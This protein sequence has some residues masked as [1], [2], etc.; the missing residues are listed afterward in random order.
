MS[1]K[2]CVHTI[3]SQF[4]NLVENRF[5]TKIKSLYSDNGGEYIALKNYL[6]V[7][8]IGHYT[9][10][11]HTPQQ[12]RISERRHQHLVET[13][14]TLLTD[15]HMPLSYWPYAFQAATYL[16]NRMPTSTLNNKTPFELLFHQNPNYMKLKQFG[17]LFYPLTRPYNTHKLQTKAMSCVFVGYSLTQNAYLC[18]NLLSRKV[19]HSRH[20]LFDETVF[21]MAQTNSC[22]SAKSQPATSALS[23]SHPVT[24]S[25]PLLYPARP[26][27]STASALGTAAPSSPSV[28]SPPTSVPSQV[29]SPAQTETSSQ[30][31]I[32]SHAPVVLP[33]AEPRPH[34]MVTRSMNN[35]YKPK[36]LF[37]VTKH[38]LPLSLEPTSVTQALTDPQWRAAMSFELTAL[39]RHDTWHLVP[40]LTGCN[41]I[42]CKW[43]FR[44]KRLAD[45]SIDRFKARLVA[46]GF[47]QRPGL[48][49]TQ[50]F[51]LVVKSVTIRTILS[52]VVMHG[53]PLHQLDINNAF[54]HGNLT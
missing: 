50:T 51:S 37:M 44:V 42:G 5:N 43:V 13:G 38:P 18:L 23:S 53:W 7:H 40:P 49:Y 6:S 41:I 16:I 32:V 19:Y 12:N 1:H 46:K 27:A 4:Q 54:L 28:A 15:A 52:V 20:V 39:I 47:N 2:S 45:G 33:T 10:A 24:I 31:L 30:N 48:D 11:P 22:S 17:C 29:C 36:S 9:T 8:G 21:P 3:F 34:C 14:L 26:P 35:I 25:L